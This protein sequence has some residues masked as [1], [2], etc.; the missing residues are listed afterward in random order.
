VAELGCGC[1]FLAVANL[2]MFP[3]DLEQY[4]ATDGSPS[5]VEKCRQ[6]VL[7]NLTTPVDSK[8]CKTMLI[9]WE[10]DEGEWKSEVESLD[11]QFGPG[12][13]LLG[14]GEGLQY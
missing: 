8:K 13:V 5:A 4:L 9:D 7:A 10:R 14:A 11:G 3:N 1:G 2:K 6:N 12:G